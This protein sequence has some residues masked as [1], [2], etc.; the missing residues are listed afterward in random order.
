MRRAAI[1]WLAVH[2]VV[3]E[4]TALKLHTAER[5]MA[6]RR[7]ADKMLKN[8][9]SPYAQKLTAFEVARRLHITDRSVIRYLADMQ[10][11]EKR[12]CPVCREDMW[13]VDGVV[14]AHPDR[15]FTECPMSGTQVR[16]GLAAIRPELYAWAEEVSA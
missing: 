6:M 3:S 12:I 9:D 5:R 8:T 2:W 13:V 10:P 7:L 1:D 16:R 14:E 15:L 4:G 11:G